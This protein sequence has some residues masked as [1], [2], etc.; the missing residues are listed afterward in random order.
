[1]ILVLGLAATAAALSGCAGTRAFRIQ[2]DLV[3]S[4]I[5]LSTEG[6]MEFNGTVDKDSSGFS[7]GAGMRLNANLDVE[8]NYVDFGE[9]S[10]N[11]TWQGFPSTGTI[12]ADGI[13]PS[14]IGSYPISDSHGID[15][16]GELGL[17]FWNADENEIFDGSPEPGFSESDNDIFYGIGVRGRFGESL[18]WRFKINRYEIWGD[19]IDT[20]SGGLFYEFE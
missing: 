16:F 2:G 1:V 11:G 14:L 5:N 3:D 6:A 8:L 19:D 13:A 18:G 17:L 15:I 7:I 20:I 10:W 4:S 9:A 12:E